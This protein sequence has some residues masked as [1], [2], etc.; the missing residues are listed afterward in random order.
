MNDNP[1][2]ATG[3]EPRTLTGDSLRYKNQLIVRFRRAIKR[4][5]QSMAS[6]EKRLGRSRGYVTDALGGR[7]EL[8][9]ELIVEVLEALNIDVAEF[10][11]GQVE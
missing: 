2:A 6:V 10:L 11:A 5:G 4:R 1:P 7:K 9:I 8:T 3:K